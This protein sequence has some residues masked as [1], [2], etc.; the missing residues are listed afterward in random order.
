MRR[1]VSKEDA[2]RE[3]LNRFVVAYRKQF[4]VELMVLEHRD[5]PDF[6]VSEGTGG[7]VLGIEVTGVYQDADEAISEYGTQDGEIE[8]EGSIDKLLAS[9]N[10]GLAEKTQKVRQYEFAGQIWLVILIA[11]PIYNSKIDIQSFGTRLVVPDNLFEKIWLII[12]NQS[13][14][15]PELYCLK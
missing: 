10:D 14:Y 3:I 11:S 6:A 12:R 2:E 13:D 8:F 7:R 9:L 15:S 5:K 4:G 1:V